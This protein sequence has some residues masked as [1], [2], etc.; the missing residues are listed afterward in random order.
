[1]SAINHASLSQLGRRIERLLY[2]GIV[3]VLFC[4]IEWY[5]ISASVAFA[6]E[7][8][9]NI[10]KLLSVIEGKREN[11]TILFLNRPSQIAKQQ[12]LERE[13]RVANTR[14]LLGLP[15]ISTQAEQTDKYKEA[16]S[17]IL[18]G[19]ANQASTSAQ[20]LSGLLDSSVSPEE[21]IHDLRKQ[22]KSIDEK[23]VLIFGLET[24]RL[25][26][27]SYGDIHY[28]VPPVFLATALLIILA[29]LLLGWLSSLYITRQRELMM[30]AALDE[31][32]WA[33]PHVLNILPLNQIELNRKFGINRHNKGTH[34]FTAIYRHTLSLFRSFVIMLFAIPMVIA[35]AYSALSV[36]EILEPTH[37]LM[38]SILG[39]TAFLLALETLLLVSQEWLLLHKK[40]F[41]D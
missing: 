27:I 7:R 1:M 17:E 34:I 13:L 20:E 2:F 19:V 28:R 41:F 18:H 12:N 40:E 16:L 36:F 6:N 3:L 15:P 29:P 31:S 4:F 37:F 39:T 9:A 26:S 10:N 32:K 8:E 33:F 14:N 23:T 30:I 38:K 11:L 25:F 24:P 22:Q 35:F 21:L 5:L